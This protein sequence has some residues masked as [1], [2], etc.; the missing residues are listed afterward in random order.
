MRFMIA[1]DDMFEETIGE[2]FEIE[3]ADHLFAVHRT[4]DQCDA[5]WRDVWSAS[6]IETGLV[7]GWGSSID[8][9][10]AHARERWKNNL[11]KVESALSKAREVRAKHEA[12]NVRQS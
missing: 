3:G 10:I 2:P 7:V 4:H 1:G 6:H 11:E 5:L 9:A 12:N 8:G